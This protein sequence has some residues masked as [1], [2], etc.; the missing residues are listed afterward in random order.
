MLFS[1]FVRKAAEQTDKDYFKVDP[2]YLDMYT[3]FTSPG[4]DLFEKIKHQCA[5]VF[6]PITSVT[7]TGGVTILDSLHED[8]NYFLYN[9]LLIDKVVSIILINHFLDII[10]LVSEKR[11]NQ[12]GV[13]EYII[14]DTND[15]VRAGVSLVHNYFSKINPAALKIKPLID[16]SN[17]EHYKPLKE[18]EAVVSLTNE[19]KEE[20]DIVDANY[21]TVERMLQTVDIAKI[22]N[23]EKVSELV[24]Y[25]IDIVNTG[26]EIT[27]AKLLD[28]SHQY[29]HYFSSK[30]SIY[31]NYLYRAKV[32]NVLNSKLPFVRKNL[33][34]IFI[35]AIYNYGLY[36][37]STILSKIEGVQDINA[38]NFWKKIKTYKD[39]FL[40]SFS[41]SEFEKFLVQGAYNWYENSKKKI[42]KGL[43]PGVVG[44][45]EKEKEIPDTRTMPLTE[46]IVEDWAEEMLDVLWNSPNKNSYKNQL[47]VSANKALD[48]ILAQFSDFAESKLSDRLYKILYNLPIDKLNLLLGS[49]KS[50][51]QMTPKEEKK[52]KVDFIFRNI[53]FELSKSIKNVIT[54]L[55]QKIKNLSRIE[56]NGIEIIKDE[57]INSFT[58]VI[59]RSVVGTLEYDEIRNLIINPL[60]KDWQDN[61]IANIDISGLIKVLFSESKSIKNNFSKKMKYNVRLDLLTERIYR[62][63]SLLG[64]SV[65]SNI[66]DLVEAELLKVKI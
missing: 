42:L 17:P 21:G 39:I 44:D 41:E 47:I 55:K 63:L 43:P 24:E 14:K 4:G 8:P 46:Q 2:S 16:P 27:L 64:I 30:K 50:I 18:K 45:E 49:E 29:I 20:Q 59:K 31:K 65:P 22:L 19:S 36:L 52:E 3:R 13:T 12:A 60:I 23:M 37:F 58:E 40:S 10:G 53:F 15:L 61:T 48:L 6:K 51:T 26:K 28:K 57:I 34:S 54:S 25:F 11:I 66:R 33:G 62:V 32:V 9:E 38:S 56:N 5:F 7:P 1:Y 35:S